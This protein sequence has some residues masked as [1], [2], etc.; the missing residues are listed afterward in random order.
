MRNR[1]DQLQKT[2]AVN[3]VG[4]SKMQAAVAKAQ[5]YMTNLGTSI[6]GVARAQAAAKNQQ[7][8]LAMAKA[9]GASKTE[10]KALNLELQS[11]INKGNTTIQTMGRAAAAS[12]KASGNAAAQGALGAAGIGSRSNLMLGGRI[13]AGAASG[14]GLASSVAGMFGS[15]MGG[16]AAQISGAVGM[17]GSMIPGL[18]GLIIGALGG[19]G[20]IV[21]GAIENAD[22]EAKAKLDHIQDIKAN[23]IKTEQIINEKNAGIAQ[24]FIEAGLSPKAAGKATQEI[25]DISVAQSTTRNAVATNLGPGQIKAIVDSLMAQGGTET[26]KLLADPT[27]KAAR[28]L[29]NSAISVAMST[30]DKTSVTM[31]A[32]E[33]ALAASTALSNLQSGGKP[34]APYVNKGGDI[35]VGK[36]VHI[37]AAKVWAAEQKTIQ[38]EEIKK[39]LDAPKVAY[40]AVL[41]K[42][43]TAKESTVPGAATAQAALSIQLDNLRTAYIDSA[44]EP[45]ILDNRDPMKVQLSDGNG[46]VKLNRESDIVGHLSSIATNTK[47][48]PPAVYNY[49]YTIDGR[50]FTASDWKKLGLGG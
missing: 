41:E 38:S 44:K 39:I 30:R 27:S 11:A 36:N 13:G 43:L 47:N 6:W 15:S 25:K 29:I 33:I 19:L 34:I 31:T 37:E 8:L 40:E 23:M 48:T 26:T 4:M 32:D 42:Y 45:V 49:T 50:N 16:A 20:S 21:F 5:S 14:I 1:F 28:D 46:V 7:Y 2:T 18:P 17:F 35:E 22:L 24:R 9:A 10:L 3:T 12:A